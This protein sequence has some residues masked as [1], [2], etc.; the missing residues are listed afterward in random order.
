MLGAAVATLLSFILSSVLGVY[1][2]RGTFPLPFPAK[3]AVKIVIAA[4]FMELCLWALEDQRGR[5][6]LLG[7]MAI[8]LISYGLATYLLNIGGIKQI[9]FN[10]YA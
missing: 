6:W 5:L 4:A 3:E 9:L 8:G 2:L 1:F 7:R 10:R